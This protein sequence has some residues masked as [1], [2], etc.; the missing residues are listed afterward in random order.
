MPQHSL[1]PRYDSPHF[2]KQEE[3]I[4]VTLT[5]K[6]KGIL[7]AILGPIIAAFVCITIIRPGWFVEWF[8]DAIAY[9]R[10]RIIVPWS[11]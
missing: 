4:I 8:W 3:A 11:S 2:C 10:S 9:I 6:D 5:Q 1:R 7:L